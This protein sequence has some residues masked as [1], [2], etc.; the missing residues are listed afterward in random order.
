[1][2]GGAGA[3]VFDGLRG[4]RPLFDEPAG[5]RIRAADGVLA[6]DFHEVEGFAEVTWDPYFPIRFLGQAVVNTATGDEKTGW[7]GGVIIGR[8]QA[9]HSIE[10]GW[11]WRELDRDA[12]VGALTDDEFAGG[13]AG[14]AGHRF[15]VRYQ[16]ARDWQLGAAWLNGR[17]SGDDRTTEYDRIFVDL[18]GRW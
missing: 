13:G 3:Y 5:N 9:I 1:M 6:E 17:R 4:G 12:V 18:S 8:A 16:F 14:T 2:L 7:L 11:N 15:F 10:F